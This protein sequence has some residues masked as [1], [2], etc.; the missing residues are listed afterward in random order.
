MT[1]GHHN[2]GY[3]VGHAAI[4]RAIGL[5]AARRSHEH[6]PGYFALLRHR[7]SSTPIGARA[8]ATFYDDYLRI[9][10][11]PPDRPYLR[12]FLSRRRDLPLFERR[13]FQIHDILM[14]RN[15]QGSYAPSSIRAG[16]PFSKIIKVIDDD[17]PE[18]EVKYR[19]ATEHASIVLSDMLSGNRIPAFSLASFL[20]R[21]RLLRFEERRLDQLTAVL[22]E[23]LRIE[24]TD[25]D[26]DH[27]YNTLFDVSDASEYST[28]DLVNAPATITMSAPST[29][30]STTSVS[31][32]RIRELRLEELLGYA[33]TSLEAPDLDESDGVLADVQAA[34][35]LGY[36]GVILSGPP[37]T[38]KS[39]YAQQVGVAIAGRPENVRFVQFHPSYQYEDFVFGYMPTKDGGFELQ[40]KEFARVCR[41]ASADPDS[42]YVLVVDEISRSDVVRVFGEA[43]TYIEMDKRDKPFIVACG[44]ELTVPKNLILIATMNLHDKGVD[45]LDAALERRFAQ[46]SLPPNSGALRTLLTN[47]APD[48]NGGYLERLIGFFERLQREPTREAH[49]GHAYFLRC[50]D[51][52]S[53]RQVWKLRLRPTLEKACA[54]DPAAFAR[55]EERWKQVVEEAGEEHDPP[56]E[57][58]DVG[59]N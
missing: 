3:V 14:N 57:P 13:A 21:D 27:I 26:G 46:V 6:L 12:P 59:A 11:A 53:A 10:D 43:L 18:G 41:D 19:L 39:W 47:R 35:K 25:H 42:Q 2:T 17:T 51:I 28:N 49:L 32:A 52:S 1:N 37:G 58:G 24:A 22:R 54:F 45:E 8:I 23:F 29:A 44:E 50:V 4:R 31:E 16:K 30:E 7:L 5:L 34:R 20:F 38:G 55:I 48:I 9:R 36:A 15:V 40:T 56:S 33:V